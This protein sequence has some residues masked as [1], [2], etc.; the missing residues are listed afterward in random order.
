VIRK[1]RKV[2]A[3]WRCFISIVMS[4]DVSINSSPA[5]QLDQLFANPSNGRYVQLLAP[6]VRYSKLPF[7]LLCRSYGCDVAYTPMIIA[8]SFN[9]SSK[10]QKAEF[11]IDPI[12]DRPLV[13]QFGVKDPNELQRAVEILTGF[14]DAV[15]INCGCPQRWV[16]HTFLPLYV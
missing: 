15:D 16:R 7:R 5:E 11:S 6:M 1:A 3:A 9:R 2:A 8:E 4:R 14:I 13:A 10:A 12:A